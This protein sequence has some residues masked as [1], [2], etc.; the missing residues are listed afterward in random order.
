MPLC[1]SIRQ[2]AYDKQVVLESSM[3][4]M[5]ALENAEKAVKKSWK[6]SYWGNEG[7]RDIPRESA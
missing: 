7:I 4:L 2:R 3:I 5:I 6:S 1:R